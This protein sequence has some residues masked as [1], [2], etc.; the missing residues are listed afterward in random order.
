M[1]SDGTG[2]LADNIAYFARALRAAGLP[3]GPGSVVDA[4]DAVEAARV[5]TREDFYWTLHA[6]F[7]T[8]REHSAIFDQAFRIFWRRRALMEKL[9]AQM[10]PIA[11]GDPTQPDKPKAGALRVAQALAPRPKPTD[12]PPPPEREISARLTMSDREILKS[13]DFAQMSAAE[14]AQAKRLVAELRLPDDALPTRRLTPSAGG[15]RIDP[16]RSFRRSLRAGGA[17]IELAMR[18]RIE[19]PPP[20]VALV[21]ISG[22]MADYSRLFLHFLHALSEKRRRV[23]AFVFATRLT[24]I[25]RELQRRDPDEALALASKR[26]EDWEGGTR[27]SA[28]LHDFNRHWSRRVLSGGP[29]VLLFTDGLEREVTPE[30]AFEMDRL[31]RSCR[32]LVWLNPLLRFDAFEARAAG[33]RAM[34]PHVH[35][36]RPVHSLASMEELCRALAGDGSAAADPRRWLARVA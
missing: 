32:R 20:L 25:S 7:V 19:A 11:P 17:A 2:H 28:A 18:D 3:L 27:I 22:S 29:V 9:I 1:T 35:E 16:R 24:N 33:I 23:H 36:F 4:L 12:E 30:L 15:R 13:K 21:D 14:I 6:V 26:A 5:G 34:L 31:K 10:S 8:R